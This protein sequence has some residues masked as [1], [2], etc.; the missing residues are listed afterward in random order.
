MGGDGCP[1]VQKSIAGLEALILETL[2]NDPT[3]KVTIE[4]TIKFGQNFA[5]ALNCIRQEG[6]IAWV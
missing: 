1:C 3:L 2:I 4:I 5:W 6:A